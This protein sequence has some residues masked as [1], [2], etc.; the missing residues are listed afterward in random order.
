MRLDIFKNLITAILIVSATCTLDNR[1]TSVVYIESPYSTLHR[2][3][4]VK[5]KMKRKENEIVVNGFQESVILYIPPSLCYWSR[6]EYII[7]YL[8]PA[9]RGRMVKKEEIR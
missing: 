2:G 4:M 6:L 8:S 9:P 1:T 3:S 7:M 5:K